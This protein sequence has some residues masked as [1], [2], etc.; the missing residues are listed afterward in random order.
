VFSGEAPAL[1][2]TTAAGA[3]HLAAQRRR[4]PLVVPQPGH[5]WIPLRAVLAA[6]GLGRG[7]LVL[8]ESGPSSTARFLEEG[9]VDELF[10]TRAPIL[11]GHGGA[12]PVLGLVEGRFFPPRALPLQLVS[13][14][15]RG[16][17]LF[18]RYGRS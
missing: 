6:A 10:L 15:R 1:V 8:V 4:V 3:S 17:F 7:A 12:T 11:V 14:R 5:G 18:L 2:V 16:S 9:A 13:A